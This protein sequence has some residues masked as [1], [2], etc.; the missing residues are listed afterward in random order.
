MIKQSLPKT[1]E[2][3]IVWTNRNFNHE[4]QKHKKLL[5]PDTA[6]VKDQGKCSDCLFEEFDESKFYARK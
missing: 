4:C 2:E 1:E 5:F 6:P 3:K